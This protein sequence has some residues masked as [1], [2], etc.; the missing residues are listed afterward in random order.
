[1]KQVLIPVADGTEEIEAVTLIDVLRRAGAKVTVASVMSGRTTIVAARGVKIEADTVIED[2]A[3]SDWDLIAL[4]GGMPG[5]EHLQQSSALLTLIRRQLDASGWL[6]AICAAPAVVLGKH[7]LIADYE[8][9]CFPAF[10]DELQPR[11]KKVSQ[12]AVVIDR[13][14]ITSQGPATAMA[15]ALQLTTCLFG[16]E[17][18]RQVGDALLFKR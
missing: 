9:T 14:L 10:Q 8:A 18:A 1:M 13:N 3:Q 7:N 12:E 17:K 4:P 11:V 5:A 2:T 15:M 6:G 16:D